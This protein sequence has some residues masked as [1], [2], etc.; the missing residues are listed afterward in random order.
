[1]NPNCARATQMDSFDIIL[2]ES[3]FHVNDLIKSKVVLYNSG[4]KNTPYTRF[5]NSITFM[6]YSIMYSVVGCVLSN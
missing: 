1:M 6:Y 4:V 3:K 2:G 5:D